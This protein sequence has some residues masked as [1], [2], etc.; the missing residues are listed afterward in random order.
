M[1]MAPSDVPDTLQALAV[2]CIESH[3]WYVTLGW[4]MGG[5]SSRE[6]VEEVQPKG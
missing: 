5:Q 3:Q 4:R 2:S 6:P 1:G